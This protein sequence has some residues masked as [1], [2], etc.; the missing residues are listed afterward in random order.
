M[1]LTLLTGIW[2]M[3]FKHM[4]ELDWEYGY[5]YALGLIAVIGFG[6]FWWFKRRKFV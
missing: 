1:P 3:N 6:M 5:Y 4:P 2:G